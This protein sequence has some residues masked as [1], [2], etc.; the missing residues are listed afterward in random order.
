MNKWIKFTVDYKSYKAGQVENLDEAVADLC[1]ESKK[2]EA[3]TE[4]EDTKARVKS[5]ADRMQVEFDKRLDEGLKQ[6]TDEISALFDAMGVK[7]KSRRKPIINVGDANEL[8]DP[9]D[10]FKTGFEFYG[11]VRKA[12]TS[13]GVDERLDR[14]MKAAAGASENINADG[15]YAVPVEFA[16]NVYNDI[17]AQDS[18]FN[19]CMTLPMGSNSLKLPALNYVTQGSFGVTAN[20]EGEA[21]TIPTSKPAYRQ[22]QLTLNKLTVLTP[23]TSELLEDGIAV[24]AM[25]N[26]LAGEAITYKIND[27]IINGTGAGMPSGVV[28]HASTVAVARNT[29]LAVKFADVS[30]MEGGFMGNDDRAEW[31]ISKADVQPQLYQISDTG[32]RA[33]YFAPGTFGENKGP[34]NMLGK[35]VRP[36]INCKTLGTA[37]DII[38]WDPKGYVF[39]YKSTGINKAMSIHLYFATDQTAFRWTFRGDGRPWRDTTLANP[40]GTLAYG[41]AVTLTTKLS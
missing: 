25:I 41:T 8:N 9:T 13:Q 19:R 23:V 32:G 17:I 20:W 6:V 1:I 7:G 29:A 28:G 15:G 36:L 37:G 18:L 10:G 40:G 38:L 4:P 2:A 34:A 3:T 21:V 14:R 5:I 35:R 27:A 30:S 26:F 33:L 22:P 24:E 12:C 39:G 11:A 16:Q 31:L